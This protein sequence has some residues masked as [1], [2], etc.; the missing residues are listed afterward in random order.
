MKQSEKTYHYLWVLEKRSLINSVVKVTSLD[1]IEVVLFNQLQALT[2]DVPSPDSLDTSDLFPEKS[3]LLV[4]EVANVDGGAA[5]SLFNYLTL[6]FVL[7]LCGTF[8]LELGVGCRLLFAEL[9][10]S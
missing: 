3:L 4:S 2:N 7:V 1:T 6:C 8:A 9:H 10:V 5:V